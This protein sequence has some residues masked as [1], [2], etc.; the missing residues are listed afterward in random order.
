MVAETVASFEKEGS[1]EKVLKKFL[2]K[3]YW[4]EVQEA[5]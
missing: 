2:I 1:I 3:L 5:C 4:K